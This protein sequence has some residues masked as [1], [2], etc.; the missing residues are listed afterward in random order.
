MKGFFAKIKNFFNFRDMTKLVG[1][2]LFKFIKSSTFYV[3]TAFVIIFMIVTAC[4]YNPSDD[5]IANIMSF[6]GDTVVQEDYFTYLDRVSGS[7]YIDDMELDIPYLDSKKADET[8][9]KE[10]KYT[11]AT[12]DPVKY[13]L[14]H[15]PVSDIAAANIDFIDLYDFSQ[16]YVPGRSDFVAQAGYA[17]AVQRFV[18]SDFGFFGLFLP[19]NE[20][21]ALQKNEDY[22]W[23]LFNSGFS[24]ETISAQLQ[25]DGA[26]LFSAS[27]TLQLVYPDNNA[28][29]TELKNFDVK[30]SLIRI[31][32]AA[33]ASFNNDR[34]E[35]ADFIFYNLYMEP[36]HVHVFKSV[37]DEISTSMRK[38]DRSYRLLRYLRGSG[39]QKTYNDFIKDSI[40]EYGEAFET[41]SDALL[42]ADR[43]GDR[44][45]REF[46]EKTAVL[47]AAYAEFWAKYDF[48]YRMIST[49][50]NMDSELSVN[51]LFFLSERGSSVVSSY[52]TPPPE[53]Y[54]AF[55]D[56]HSVIS[57]ENSEVNSLLNINF[58]AKGVFE[59]IDAFVT[60]MQQGGYIFT[61]SNVSD[62]TEM[63]RDTLDLIDLGLTIK[64]D[65]KTY[66][67]SFAFLDGRIESLLKK[68][69]RISHDNAVIRYFIDGYGEELK[70]AL[71]ESLDLGFASYEEVLK[72]GKTLI[73]ESG[74][75]DDYIRKVNFSL[76]LENENLSDDDLNG[77]YGIVNVMMFG[78]S[79]YSIKS[80]I[81]QIRFML[82]NRETIGE[83]TTALGLDRGFGYMIFGFNILYLF[84]IVVGI[85]I[86][87]GTIAGEHA[88]G[89]IKL[90]LIRPYKR[91][92][93]LLSKMYMTAI[94]MLFY[95]IISFILMYVV[96]GIV[97]GFGSEYKVLILFN[98][99]KV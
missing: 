96:G 81:T 68:A 77:I 9:S 98:A 52:V 15:N 79:K 33:F 13:Y 58:T 71:N 67:A 56:R 51:F 46:Q 82:D 85:V 37:S 57:D 29:V 95:F 18:I 89:T 74:Y 54:S 23:T 28:L 49:N 75:V 63:M 42:A 99:E 78:V 30:E 73:I 22:I 44:N 2:E 10:M 39:Y 69:V 20:E 41:L 83:L 35:Y 84:L 94:A 36:I 50:Y 62:L 27:E 43:V 55:R 16:Y 25:T 91:W 4:V 48:A 38:L 92:Q 53:L 65:Q 66:E 1:G 80:D 14:G 12:V 3:L 93:F 45:S 70:A 97:W 32:N 61:K 5:T 60:T 26:L 7:A 90:L 64:I 17:G 34:A 87:A 6:L 76:I 24:A 40:L 11:F 8:F 47:R 31:M 59:S 21:F 88:T 86:G 19:Y 72:D